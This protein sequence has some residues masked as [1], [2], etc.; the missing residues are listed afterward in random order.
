MTQAISPQTALIYVMVLVS[1]ADASMSDNELRTIGN[2][3]G[4]FPV[5][6][7]MDKERLIKAAEEC[8]AIM[9][10]DDGLETVLGLAKD[11]LPEKLRE[12]AYAFAVEVA[13]A[14]DRL[15]QEELRVLELIRARLSID[16]LAAG[17][18]ERSARARH[19][20]A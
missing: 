4:T 11:A 3:V 9:S 2:I 19:M 20:R 17:A 1:A 14:D 10:E 7:G 8:G 15:G 5:F 13:T 12:T 18:I 6:S 16:R